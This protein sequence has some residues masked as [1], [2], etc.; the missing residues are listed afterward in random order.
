MPEFVVQIKA[1]QSVCGIHVFQRHKP[2]DR[3]TLIACKCVAVDLYARMN[4][5]RIQSTAA[6]VVY[7]PS[8]A[9]KVARRRVNRGQVKMCG[10]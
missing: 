3:R 1:V 9:A 7:N 10:E 2:D 5:G 8:G 6:S 4:G